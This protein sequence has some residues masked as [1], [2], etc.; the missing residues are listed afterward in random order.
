MPLT[1]ANIQRHSSLPL[2]TAQARRICLVLTPGLGE[3]PHSPLVV[4][5]ARG[6]ARAFVLATGPLS[7]TLDK[8]VS[9]PLRLQQVRLPAC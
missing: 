1:A 2:L 8:C 4:S 9:A 5:V 3:D 7:R 6:A